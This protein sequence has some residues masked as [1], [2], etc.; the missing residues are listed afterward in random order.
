MAIQLQGVGA[1][2]IGSSEDASA[3]IHVAL[4][5][6]AGN[7]YRYSGFTGTI[8]AALGAN[9]ELLQFRFLTGTKTKCIVRKIMLDGI[10]IVA[11]ATALGPLGW[12]VKPARSWSVAGSGGTRIATT[13]DNLQLRQAN[14]ASQV[15]DLGIA[16][17]GALT[18]GTKTLDAN[19]IGQAIISIGTGAVTTYQAIPESGQALLDVSGGG[20]PL[21]L[22]DQEGFSILTTHVGP[23][24]LTYVVGFTIDWL[25]VAAY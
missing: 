23:A 21:V 10:G 18:A 19:A 8:G 24:A 14:P 15:N 5:G 20:A 11:V 1:V 13:G 4:H 22:G 7:A 2:A 3:P 12:M 25:E 17:T 6:M 16:T 9:S